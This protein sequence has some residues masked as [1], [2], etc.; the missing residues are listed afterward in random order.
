[1]GVAKDATTPRPLLPAIASRKMVEVHLDLVD[2]TL[3]QDA[4]ALEADNGNIW[5][6]PRL[7][8][9]VALLDPGRPAAMERARRQRH[10][11]RCLSIDLGTNRRSCHDKLLTSVEAFP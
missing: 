8:G 6:P 9:A 4:L 10:L 1:M 2:A 5:D 7:T 11:R 3:C